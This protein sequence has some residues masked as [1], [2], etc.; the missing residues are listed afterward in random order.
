MTPV[1]MRHTL[2]A[3]AALALVTAIATPPTPAMAQMDLKGLEGSLTQKSGQSALCNDNGRFGRALISKVQNNSSGVSKG[4]GYIAPA[5]TGGTANANIYRRTTGQ[6]L[7][8]RGT[9]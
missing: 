8:R 6:S 4:K 1:A 3:I 2:S 7:I 9:D 5:T